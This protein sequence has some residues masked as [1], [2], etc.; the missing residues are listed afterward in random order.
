MSVMRQKVYFQEA[1]RKLVFHKQNWYL[2]LIIPVSCKTFE[3]FNGAENQKRFLKILWQEQVDT[4][5]NGFR[6]WLKSK[7]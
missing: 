5:F 1:K 7:I 4:K 6:E 2:N 3:V